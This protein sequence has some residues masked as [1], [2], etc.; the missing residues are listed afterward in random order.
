MGNVLE[1]R[2]ID[3]DLNTVIEMQKDYIENIYKKQQYEVCREKCNYLLQLLP[4]DVKA[5]KIVKRFC[6]LTISKCLWH[7]GMHEMALECADISI[8]YCDTAN[9]IGA[10]HM[11]GLIFKDMGDKKAA[12]YYLNKCLNWYKK[13]EMYH[14]IAK[15]LD[16]K[17]ELLESESMFLEAFTYYEKA[18]TEGKYKNKEKFDKE[19]NN[20]Y[21]RLIK[22]YVKQGEET[23]IKAY[24]A[25]KQIEDEA[26]RKTAKEELE[27]IFR[28]EV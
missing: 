6:Y 15:I 19:Y 17:A 5:E 16:S 21:N 23:M 9:K 3:H 27:K 4:S 8:L 1:L 14:E 13:N 24:K 10:I 12:L 7:E 26:I 11:K 22:L 18:K 2:K 28:K 20:A 25:L